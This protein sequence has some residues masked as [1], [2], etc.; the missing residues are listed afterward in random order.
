MSGHG[1]FGMSLVGS[2]HGVKRWIRSSLCIDQHQGVYFY[3]AMDRD[4]GNVVWWR[5][6]AAYPPFQSSAA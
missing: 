1:G 5:R 4:V 6:E 2:G 3:Q